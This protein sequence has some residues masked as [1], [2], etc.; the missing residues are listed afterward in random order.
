MIVVISGD[1]RGQRGKVLSV[2]PVKGMIVVEGIN[3]VYKH[4][5]PSRRNPQ[6]GRLQ[7]ERPIHISNV[8]PLNEK[9]NRPTRV[10][11]VTDGGEKKRV[12]SDG[13]QL[14]LVTRKARKQ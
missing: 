14:E 2:D 5:R 8:L 10:R 12:A 4:V 9:T 11:F 13:T 6:G 7:I 1:H 3:R